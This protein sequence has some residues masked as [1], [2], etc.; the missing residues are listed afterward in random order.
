[1]G[2]AEILTIVFVL[3]KVFNLVSW[4]WWMVFLPEIIATVFYLVIFIA[5]LVGTGGRRKVVRKHFNKF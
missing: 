5:G 2:F 4:S 1:M 3:A